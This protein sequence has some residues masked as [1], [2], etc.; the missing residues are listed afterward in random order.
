[1]TMKL[2]SKILAAFAL[3]LT[4]ALVDAGPE[5]PKLISDFA[6]KLGAEGPE[7]MAFDA[8]TGQ[9][10]VVAG[11]NIHRTNRKGGEIVRLGGKPGARYRG[12]TRDAEGNLLA[13]AASASEVHTFDA[14]GKF[15]G[16]VKLPAS[17]SY[18]AISCSKS[19]EIWYVSDRS[20]IVVFK[21][22]GAK[23]KEI[24]IPGGDIQGIAATAKGELWVV[25]DETL[26]V[27]LLDRKGKPRHAISLRELTKHT[28][29]EGLWLDEE[30]KTLRVS[31][32]RSSAVIEIDISIFD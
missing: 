19:G 16:A 25:D 17:P 21:C 14:N 29:P 28:D 4:P 26:E 8:G 13:L 18:R 1:M 7:G 30:G 15:L 20:G 23:K 3:F 11:S 10:Y 27:T 6:I 12:L 32:D 2:K 24:E 9:L 22:N 31:F 5:K